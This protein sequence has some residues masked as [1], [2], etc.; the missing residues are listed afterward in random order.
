[1]R[2]GPLGGAYENGSLAAAGFFQVKSRFQ[3]SAG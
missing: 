2:L 3:C 1:M